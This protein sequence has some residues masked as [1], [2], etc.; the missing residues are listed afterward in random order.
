MVFRIH[1][2][3][4]KTYKAND[5]RVTQGRTGRSGIRARTGAGGTLGDRN[6]LDFE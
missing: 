1:V 6:L 5:K 2:Y 3:M 4:N